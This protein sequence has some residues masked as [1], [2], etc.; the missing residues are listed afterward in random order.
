VE[1]LDKETSG[2]FGRALH[3][4]ILPPIV[5]DAELIYNACVGAGTNERV[6]S[7]DPMPL[8]ENQ[9]LYSMILAAA[10]YFSSML[11]LVF[12]VC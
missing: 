4:L 10:F 5:L 11:H 1:V 7:A 8:G 12:A 2:H 9:V 3:Y 6:S